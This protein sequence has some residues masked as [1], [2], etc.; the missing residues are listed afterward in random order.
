MF[1]VSLKHYVLYVYAVCIYM[2]YDGKLPHSLASLELASCAMS[3]SMEL[4]IF[5]Y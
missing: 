2:L 3:I 4:L 5:H 1:G